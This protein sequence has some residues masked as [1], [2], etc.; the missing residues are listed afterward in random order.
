M[1]HLRY[2]KEKT[3]MENTTY[4]RANPNI[5]LAPP[6]VTFYNEI[7]CL[8]AKDPA[9][10]VVYDDDKKEVKM[11]VDG[12]L[13]ANAIEKLMPDHV[14]FGNVRLNITVIPANGTGTND[15]EL[16]QAAFAG[17]DILKYTKSTQT[18]FG[19]MNYVVFN[20]EIAQFYNDEMQDINGVR[21]MLYADIAK[22]VFVHANVCFN[23]DSDGLGE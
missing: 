1:K 16:I 7:D 18:P 19:P 3:T 5:R 14:D 4:H 12:D 20:K 9:V 13:K 23:T 15:L 2:K 21:S 8:F 11:L 6:W 22:D 17:N 10:T